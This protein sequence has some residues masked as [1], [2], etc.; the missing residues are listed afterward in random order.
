M[1]DTGNF[2]ADNANLL[3]PES[4]F[5]WG[6]FSLQGEYFWS[7]VSSEVGNDPQFQGAYLFGSY[8]ITG[9]HRTYSTSDGKFSRVKPHSPFATA[10]GTGAW[11]VAARWSWLDLNDSDISGGEQNNFTL[12][13][14]WYLNQNYR[15]LVN[16]V[17]A[18]VEDRGT[19][20]DGTADIFQMRFQA[21]F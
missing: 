6:P 12:G 9:E 20:E 15:I 7:S 14:N 8:F 5:V 3:N 18:D 21:D 13:L 1:V 4:A 16:Y 2:K 17:L 10:G 19:L 11:E